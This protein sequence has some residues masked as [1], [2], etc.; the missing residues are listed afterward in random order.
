MTFHDS[1]LDRDATQNIQS[2]D[3]FVALQFDKKSRD[4]HTVIRAGALAEWRYRSEDGEPMR[5]RAADL[6]HVTP[7]TLTCIAFG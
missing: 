5:H 3:G 4:F 7:R 1:R 2:H 6:P